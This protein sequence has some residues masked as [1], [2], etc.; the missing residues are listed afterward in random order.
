[1]IQIIV[2]G[3]PLVWEPERSLADLLQHLGAPIRTGVAVAVN[4]DIIPAA[5]RA[6]RRLQAGDRVEILTLAGGG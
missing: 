3:E 2:N 4:A 1:M 5:Q 6:G